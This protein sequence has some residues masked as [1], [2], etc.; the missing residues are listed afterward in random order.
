MHWQILRKLLYT[1][2]ENNFIAKAYLKDIL[3]INFILLNYA[4]YCIIVNGN[5][6]DTI[7]D[8]YPY[9]ST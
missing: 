5:R 2:I 8:T 7:D 4:F 1:W 6:E 9:Y 3:K